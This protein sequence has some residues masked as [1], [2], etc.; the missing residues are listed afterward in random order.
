[1]LEQDVN[2]KDSINNPRI[3]KLGQIG[4][5]FGFKVF[6]VWIA[7]S[8][9]HGLVCYFVPMTGMEY[10]PDSGRDTGLWFVSTVS[11]TMVIHVVTFKLYIESVYWN[12]V[13]IACGFLSVLFYYLS[14]IVLNEERMANLFQ[15]QL[16]HLFFNILGNPMFWVMI[17]LGPTLAVLPDCLVKSF[18][19]VFH[20]TSVDKVML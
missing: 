14:V 11:F 1:V 10:F 5:Y 4:H 8:A 12:K 16:I 15:P 6:W 7:H 2:A 17:I 3:Y 13:N 20:P 19:S 18:R 9:W